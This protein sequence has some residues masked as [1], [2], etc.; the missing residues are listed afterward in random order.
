MIR[1]YTSG[2][3]PLYSSEGLLGDLESLLGSIHV[4]TAIIYG[5]KAPCEVEM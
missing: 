1:V 2:Y 5:Y 3:L 4:A